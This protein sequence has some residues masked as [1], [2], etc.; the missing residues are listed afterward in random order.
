[1]AGTRGS[2]WLAREHNGTQDATAE[3][4]RREPY[5]DAGG[6]RGA[7]PPGQHSP[8]RASKAGAA[9]VPGPAQVGERSEGNSQGHERPGRHAGDLRFPASPQPAQAEDP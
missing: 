1:M 3:M 6:F 8:P 4:L 2:T 9:P 7:V 5:R